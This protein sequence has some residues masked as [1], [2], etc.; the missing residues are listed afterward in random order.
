[1]DL[2][3]SLLLA[4][5]NGEEFLKESLEVPLKY[6]D[7]AVVVDGSP[8]GPS[9][10]G[11][12]GVIDELSLAYPDKIQYTAGTFANEDG[13]WATGTQ[14]TVAL[15]HVTGN[16]VIQH[17]AD[18]VYSE[19]DMERLIEAIGRCHPRGIIYFPLIDFW[20]TQDRIRLYSSERM[21]CRPRVGVIPVFSTAYNPFYGPTAEVHLDDESISNSVYLHDIFRYHYGWM[22]FRRQ[23]NKHLRNVL[24]RRWGEEME[25]YRTGPRED[26][27]KWIVGHI[28]DYPTYPYA[29]PFM[30]QEP[31]SMRDKRLSYLDGM[32]ETILELED[33]YHTSLRGLVIERGGY[34]E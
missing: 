8:S 25:A 2:T 28:L 13:T 34:V 14:K 22:G 20:L 21:Y 29:L 6:V 18:M 12:K 11:T 15:S 32:A 3:I 10:D 23:F 26:L 9:S 31:A 5:Y 1:V 16:Y 24:G 7:Q 4:V 27:V 17:E 19:Q 30:G 33:E